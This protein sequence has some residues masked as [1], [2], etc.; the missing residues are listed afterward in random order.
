MITC[1]NFQIEQIALFVKAQKLATKY[2]TKNSSYPDYNYNI[3][4]YFLYILFQLS[5]LDSIRKRFY[6]QRTMHPMFQ[7]LSEVKTFTV[8]C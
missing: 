7:G 6:Q 8:Y 2:S 3:F 4:Y 5:I 1:K